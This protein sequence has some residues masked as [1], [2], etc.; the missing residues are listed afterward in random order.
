MW[1][2]KYR[3]PNAKWKTITEEEIRDYA[4]YDPVQDFIDVVKENPGVSFR[5][6]PFALC[7]F[8]PDIEPI[9]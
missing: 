5:L 6:N 7:K 9:K 8:D 1:F 3:E 4:Y 2:L